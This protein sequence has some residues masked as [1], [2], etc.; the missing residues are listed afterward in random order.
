MT[1]EEKL[2]H[3]LDVTTEN[4]NARNAKAL[5]EYEGALRKGLE[6]HKEDAERKAALSLQ[7]ARES[8]T[9]KKNAELA[10]H[11]IQMKEQSSRLAQELKDKLFN[12]V[13]DKLERYMDTKEYQD[14][15]VAQI[16]HAKEF[17]GEDEVIIYIDPADSGKINSLSAVTNTTIRISEYGFGGGIRALVKSG[18]VLIDQ[19]FETRLKEEEESFVFHI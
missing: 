8:L 16:R 7:L 5:E 13:K 18:K 1:T 6:E 4:V 9:K 14:Y 2:K 3:F 10:K 15:L 12:E 19:S 11:Q 17:A